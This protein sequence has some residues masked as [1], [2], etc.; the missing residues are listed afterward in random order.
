MC[1]FCINGSDRYNMNLTRMQFP[2]CAKKTCAKLL[3]ATALVHLATAF[4]PAACRVCKRQSF[5]R[6]VAVSRKFVAEF[7]ESCG[8][9]VSDHL[10]VSIVRRQLFFGVFRAARDVLA[11]WPQADVLWTIERCEY[12]AQAFV[13]LGDTPRETESDF[14]E[15]ERRLTD[16]AGLATAICERQMELT[17]DGPSDWGSGSAAARADRLAMF[18]FDAAEEVAMGRQKRFPAA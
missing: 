13:N 6:L 16:L 5:C 1:P 3:Y 12:L 18:L 8:S 10:E 15:V 9:E 17:G 4:E 11:L 7:K 14:R 2:A